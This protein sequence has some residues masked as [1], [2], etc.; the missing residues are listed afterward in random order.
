LVAVG[1]INTTLSIQLARDLAG[2][3]IATFC[4]F[5]LGFNM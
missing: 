2:T 3:A 5:Y 1:T 4:T